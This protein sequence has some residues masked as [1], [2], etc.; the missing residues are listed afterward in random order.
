MTKLDELIALAPLSNRSDYN[1]W[2]ESVE[3]L[4]W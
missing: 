1:G 4:G 3:P 2:S